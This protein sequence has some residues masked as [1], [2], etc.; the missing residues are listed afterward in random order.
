[1]KIRQ[2][3][4]ATRE[5]IPAALSFLREPSSFESEAAVAVSRVLAAVRTRRDEALVEQVRRFD[6]ACPGPEALRVP[7]ETIDRS[8]SAIDSTLR[9]S[10]GAAAESIRR[11]HKGERPAYAAGLKAPGV[12]AEIRSWPLDSVGL[13]VPGGRA[14]YPTTL[15]MLAIP[16]QL[17]GVRRIAVAT[18]AGPEG[19]PCPAVLATA[20]ILGLGEVL[21]IGGA[22]AIGAFA[23]GTQTIPRVD[24]IF[25]PGNAW[26]TEA[27]RQVFG[28]VGID[29]LSGPTELAV[30]SDGSAPAR[31]IAADLL[32]Q[33]EHDPLASAVLFTTD[34]DEVERVDSELEEILRD[35]PREEIQRRSLEFR[36]ALIACG[37]ERV[38][39][40]AANHLAPEH[41]TVM[42]RNPGRWADRVPTAAAIFLGP[43]SPAAAGDYGAGP[44]HCLPTGGAA[45]FASPVGVGDFVRRQSRLEMGRESLAS[46]SRWMA[47]LAEAE[48]FPGHALSL[49]VREE[50]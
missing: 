21:A 30:L 22:A 47:P 6:W 40:E 15:L 9:D 37:C 27:K 20:A 23:F 32:A 26:V 10:L 49:C 29:G 24:K 12:R 35:S 8:I 17:A 39:A 31:W 1:M 13:Y 43:F 4:I 19:L 16:A 38:A 5:E 7:R 42:A 3:R 46:A 41:L 18:P 36:G 50:P 45:R 14:S 25:G 2:L 11:F 48:R 33:A 44:N 28:A 34:R